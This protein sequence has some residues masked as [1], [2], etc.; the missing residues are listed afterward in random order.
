MAEGWEM[1]VL[2]MIMRAMGL[3]DDGGLCRNIRGFA[4]RLWLV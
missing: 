2:I 4:M 3:L 1:E